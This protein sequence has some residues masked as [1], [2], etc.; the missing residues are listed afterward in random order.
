MTSNKHADL[1]ARADW[2][3][4]VIEAIKEMYR[5]QTHRQIDRAEKKLAVL[6]EQ[7]SYGYKK[8]TNEN[9]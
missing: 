4:A 6:M 2:I 5:G 3:E 9:L 7:P 8:D 1:S